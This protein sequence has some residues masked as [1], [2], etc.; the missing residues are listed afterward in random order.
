MTGHTNTATKTS[1]RNAAG[2]A[3]LEERLNVHDARYGVLLDKV[4]AD[5]C[6]SSKMLDILEFTMIGH[7]R[8]EFA[9]ILLEKVSA[10]RCPSIPMIE[11]ISALWADS[12][13]AVDRYLASVDGPE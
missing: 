10:D 7:E 6:P 4:R 13:T 2:Q 1:S 11:R 3:E 5:N 8:E 9:R 12:R